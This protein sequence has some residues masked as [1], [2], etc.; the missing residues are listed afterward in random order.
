MHCEHMTTTG[1][2]ENFPIRREL[3]RTVANRFLRY[4]STNA[5]RRHIVERALVSAVLLQLATMRPLVAGQETFLVD[6]RLLPGK[7][8]RPSDPRLQ[9]RYLCRF[10]LGICV[11]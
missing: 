3:S 5:P 7:V 6:H 9:G 1:K 10:G 2:H 11:L 8:G 4:L